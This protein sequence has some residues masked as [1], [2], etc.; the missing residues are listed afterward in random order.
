LKLQPL[1]ECHGAIIAGQWQGDLL[2]A[3]AAGNQR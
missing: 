2:I 1:P 3:M